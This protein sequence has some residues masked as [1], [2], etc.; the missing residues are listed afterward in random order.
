ML[1]FL[2]AVE[3]VSRSLNH[4]DQVKQ[5]ATVLSIDVER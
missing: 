4:A 1:W 5:L 3:V 2:G